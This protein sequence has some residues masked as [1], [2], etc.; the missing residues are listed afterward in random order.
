MSNAEMK[1][2]LPHD[3]AHGARELAADDLDKRL[4]NYVPTNSRTDP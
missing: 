3:E 4:P 1:K 2:R